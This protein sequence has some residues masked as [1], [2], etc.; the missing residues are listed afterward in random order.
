[1]KFM[2]DLHSKSV[3]FFLLALYM[4]HKKQHLLHTS[5]SNTAKGTPNET[6]KS[7]SK[8]QDLKIYP[9]LDQQIKRPHAGQKTIISA[10]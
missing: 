5:I 10:Q 4:K 6:H 3:R 9:S 2:A 7:K 8:R 1:M